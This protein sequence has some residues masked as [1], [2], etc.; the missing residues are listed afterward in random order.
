[1]R[2]NIFNSGGVEGLKKM[3]RLSLG[4]WAMVSTTGGYFKGRLVGF[5]FKDGDF[6]F[7]LERRHRVV[8]TP[9]V[10]DAWIYS[11]GMRKP[12][13]PRWVFIAPRSITEGYH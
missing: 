3:L 2:G 5:A 11:K 9:P 10:N 4:Q 8:F 7:L 13:G 12:G 1:M 6:Y